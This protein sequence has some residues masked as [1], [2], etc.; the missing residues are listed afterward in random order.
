MKKP[1]HK[2][3]HILQPRKSARRSKLQKEYAF[4]LPE[5]NCF[6]KSSFPSENFKNANAQP[7]DRQSR[8][9]TMT[10]KLNNDNGFKTQTTITAGH[11]S[12]FKKLAVQWLNE[13]QFFNQTLL[14]AD[15]FVLR[16]RQLLK[17]ANRQTV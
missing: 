9:L 8:N 2:S 5:K 15:S 11:N 3:I 10:A 14:P 4:F 13:V 7:Y 17:P 1:T 16:N 12:G 6:K